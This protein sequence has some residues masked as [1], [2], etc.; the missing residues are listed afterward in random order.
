[1]AGF[2]KDGYGGYQ[3]WIGWVCIAFL[4]VVTVVL[5]AMKGK[6]GFYKKPDDAPGYED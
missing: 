2:L 4:I 6:P 3:R 1:M 5:T